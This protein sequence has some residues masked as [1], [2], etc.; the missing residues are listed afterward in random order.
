MR[1][2]FGG[3]SD[4]F[5]SHDPLLDREITRIHAGGYCIV[6]GDTIISTL[7]GSCI[8]VCLRDSEAGIAGMNHFLLPGEGPVRL[9]ESVADCRYGA[10]AIHALVD[11][12]ALMGARPGRIVAKL[13]GGSEMLTQ[14]R[15]VGRHNIEFAERCLQALGI[16][17]QASDVGGSEHR[18]IRFLTA[19]GQVRVQRGG[20]RQKVVPGRLISDS[21]TPGGVRRRV[22]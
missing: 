20:S 7:L 1:R 4:G 14:L 22:V 21:A 19:S 8:T 12:M 16:P 15:P 18:V 3:T 9:D 11:G 17:I 5:V 6:D 2:V 13:F 10:P